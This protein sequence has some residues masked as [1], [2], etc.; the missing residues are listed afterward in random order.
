MSLSRKLG[1]GALPAHF[2]RLLAAAGKNFAVKSPAAV[3][4]LH[5]QQSFY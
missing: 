5:S 3:A 1:D 4:G 2:T